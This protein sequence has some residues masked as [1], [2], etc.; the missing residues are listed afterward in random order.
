VRLNLPKHPPHKEHYLKKKIKT[1]S[2]QIYTG[3]P[4][5]IRQPII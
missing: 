5:L 2:F 4:E 1:M 3:Q